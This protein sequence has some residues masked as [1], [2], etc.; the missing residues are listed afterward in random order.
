MFT[1]TAVVVRSRDD[2]DLRRD[3]AN[4]CPCAPANQGATERRSII[5]LDKKIREQVQMLA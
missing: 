2:A 4:G 5:P 3:R 1:G